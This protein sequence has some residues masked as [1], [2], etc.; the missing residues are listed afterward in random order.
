MTGDVSVVVTF[1]ITGEQRELDEF[2]SEYT[3]SGMLNSGDNECGCMVDAE[4]IAVE[5]HPPN[6]GANPTAVIA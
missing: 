1:R 6:T 3:P 5:Y 2:L 4:V